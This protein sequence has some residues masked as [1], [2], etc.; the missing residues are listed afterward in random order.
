MKLGINNGIWEVKGIKF[1]EAITKISNFGFKY[2]DI[3]A[4]GSVN[5]LFLNG[6]MVL[7]LFK[8]T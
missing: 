7:V 5:P 3:L 1:E 4:L 2:V 6:N 8:K